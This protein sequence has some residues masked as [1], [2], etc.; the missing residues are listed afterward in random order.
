MAEK[1]EGLKV[2]GYG[3][4]HCKCGSSENVHFTI[5][6]WRDTDYVA[7]CA[8]GIVTVREAGVKKEVYQFGGK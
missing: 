4:F 2:T 7:W 5:G 6:S 8:C 1:E 3:I